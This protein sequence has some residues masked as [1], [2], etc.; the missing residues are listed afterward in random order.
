MIPLATSK[1]DI[2]GPTSQHSI[3]E[4]LI[5]SFLRLTL[6]GLAPTPGRISG[7]DFRPDFSSWEAIPRRGVPGRRP[8]NVK[9]KVFLFSYGMRIFDFASSK[10]IKLS[11]P[12]TQ[13][14]RTTGRVAVA[15][16]SA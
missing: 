3:R 16:R 13:R 7:P 8:R 12:F 4:I 6:P 14:D 15:N 2:G 1:S 5:T 11:E 10:I 9:E